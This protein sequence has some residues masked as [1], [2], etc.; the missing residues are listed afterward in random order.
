MRQEYATLRQS[1]LDRNTANLSRIASYACEKGATQWLTAKPDRE[2]GFL[3]S[4]HDFR[5]LLRLR[6]NLSIDNL[7]LKCVCSNDFSV[8]HALQCPTGGFVSMRH[9]ELRDLFGNVMKQ[10]CNDVSIEPVLN[11]VHPSDEIRGNRSEGA[12][13]DIAATGFWQRGR[14]AFFDVRVF[15]PLASTNAAAANAT[16]YR[17]HESEKINA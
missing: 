11:P 6:Y 7:P 12:R 5:D 17:R 4:K 10:V 15:N 16:V 8:N 1:I 3:L 13:L 9:N 14:K 2:A